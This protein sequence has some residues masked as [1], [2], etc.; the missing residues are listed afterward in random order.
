MKRFPLVLFLALISLPP[1]SARTEP[2][3][4]TAVT[5]EDKLKN[6]AGSCPERV[7]FNE[8]PDNIEGRRFVYRSFDMYNDCPDEMD[9]LAKTPEP[10]DDRLLV[11]AEKGASLP[12]RYRAAWVLIQR[13]N[14]KVVPAL[15]KMTKSDSAEERYLAWHLY[16]NGIRNQKFA[17][18][19]SFDT[20]LD[21]CKNEKNRFVRE[22][23]MRFFGTCKAKEA[24]PLLTAAMKEDDKYRDAVSALGEIGD[25]K[26]VP[27]ILAQAKKEQGNRNSYFRALG[28][29]GT[30]EAVD[31][32]IEC[33]DEG[34][35]VVEALFKSGSP[36]ALPAIEKYLARLKAKERP[37]EL[38]LAVAQVSVLRLKHTDPR[39][40]LLALAEDRKQ[41]RDM[42]NHALE[43]LEHYDKKPLAERILKLYRADTDDWTRMFYIR[44]LKDLPGDDITEAMID[45][46]L[47]DDENRF[48]FSHYDLL[49]ALNQRLNTSYRTMA[50]L[51]QYLK[52]QRAAKEK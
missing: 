22:L 8:P 1:S 6:L 27:D 12:E 11:M 33:L 35:F 47:T 13:R 37:N 36:K 43:A 41:S 45:Q 5:V 9:A 32:L 15:E 4:Q 39:E 10:I 38:D 52:R 29:I 17:V 16:I 34:C 31:Y 40:H 21:Q 28:Q 18:P 25:T 30:S 49:E 24:I 51:V 7:H 23:I 46:A 48:Y 20:M 3:K 2:A 50:P 44:L 14:P 26:T 19:Q 42:R